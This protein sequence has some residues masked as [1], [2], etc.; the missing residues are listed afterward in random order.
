[1]SNESQMTRFRGEYE[2]RSM[3]QQRNMI[4]SKFRL[5]R[6]G[7]VKN[8][9]N[10][11]KEPSMASDVMLILKRGQQININVAKSTTEFYYVASIVD[12]ETKIPVHGFCKREFILE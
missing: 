2:R 8:G 5:M 10:V 11:R 6:V 7:E 9:L 1:M 12:G 3:E 4:E